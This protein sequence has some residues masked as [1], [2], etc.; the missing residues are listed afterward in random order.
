MPVEPVFQLVDDQGN[1]YFMQSYSLEKDTDQTAQTLSQLGSVLTLPSGWTFRSLVLK[2]DYNLTA[3]N[4][5]ATVIQ[6]DLLNTYQL[7]PG[8]TADQF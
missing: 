5:M 8:A 6:D 3:L 4:N 7:A 1:V 2:A